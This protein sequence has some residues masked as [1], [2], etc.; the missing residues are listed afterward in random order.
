M[1]LYQTEGMQWN[2]RFRTANNGFI[3]YTNGDEI[4]FIEVQGN[5]RPDN[6]PQKNGTPFLSCDD[7]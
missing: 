7:L 3:G 4:E 6:R 5:Y 1:F 2:T